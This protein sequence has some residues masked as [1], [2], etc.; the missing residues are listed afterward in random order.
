MLVSLVIAG[1][2]GCNPTDEQITAEVMRLPIDWGDGGPSKAAIPNVVGEIVCG[3]ARGSDRAGE[4]WARAMGIP[5]HHEPILEEDIRRYGKYAGPRMRNRR[6]AERGTHAICFWDGLSAGTPDMA[7][8]MLCRGKPV[9][10]APCRRERR[11]QRSAPE[12]GVADQM[13]RRDADRE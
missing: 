10:G 9:I 4:R 3:D 7:M 6:M 8:R 1:S 11:G 13:G 12:R 2:R 5:V